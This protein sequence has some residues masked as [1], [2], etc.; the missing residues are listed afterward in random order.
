MLFGNKKL[1]DIKPG[2]IED[3]K[4]IKTREGRKPATIDKALSFVRHLFNYARRCDKFYGNNP[5][6][7]SELLPMNNQKT[8]IITPEE[9]ALLIEYAEEPLKSTIRIALLTG[10]RLNSI[11][12]LTWKCVDLNH[13][14]ITIEAVYSKKENPCPANQQCP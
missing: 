10:L 11:R 8:R 9:E 1:S 2:D 7:I 4:R 3:Y 12:T 14:T 13:N 5:V 6:S